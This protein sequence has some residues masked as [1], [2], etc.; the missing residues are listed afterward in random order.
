MT[1]E[2]AIQSGLKAGFDADANLSALTVTVYPH[3]AP[4]AAA[5]PFVTYSIFGSDTEKYINTT[6][7]TTLQLTQVSL[8]VD[9]WAGTVE[10]R[11]LILTSIKDII[12][13]MRGAFGTENMNIRQ[14]YIATLSTFSENDITGTDE[15]IYRASVGIDITY[16]WS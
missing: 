5:L 10:N 14:S 16:N 13:G 8:N 7:Q 9:V 2:S 11:A 4:Q 12:H 15:E 3:T 6:D 1:I